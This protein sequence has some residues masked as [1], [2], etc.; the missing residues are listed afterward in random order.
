MSRRPSIA[1]FHLS[2]LKALVGTRDASTI[3][4]LVERYE[5]NAL[6]NEALD[7]AKRLFT[8]IIMGEFSTT[9]PAVEDEALQEVVQHL[10]EY[11]QDLRYSDSLFW[12]A[13]MVDVDERQAKYDNGP[14]ELL[15]YLLRGRPLIGRR[16]DSNNW[17]YYA[18]FTSDE[19]KR[20]FDFIR[21]QQHLRQEYDF[22]A[23]DNWMKEVEQAGEDVWFY[24]S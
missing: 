22:E 21:S 6:D 20:L 3:S 2:R 23:A 7:R 18:Y 10:V 17:N 5:E 12:E 19:A 15:G 13:L 11:S 1:G 24:V 8:A 14:E 4:S 16:T 9:P